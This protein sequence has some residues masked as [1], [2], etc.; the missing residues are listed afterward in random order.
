MKRIT[1]IVLNYKTYDAT[2]KLCKEMHEQKCSRYCINYLIIDN[3][4]NNN[5]YEIIKNSLSEYHD[6]EVIQTKKNEGYARGN[7]V[8]LKYLKRNPPDYVIISNN[9]I[10]FENNTFL[11]AFI[12]KYEQLPE[13]KAIVAPTQLDGSGNKVPLKRSIPTFFDDMFD[14]TVL[15]RKLRNTIQNETKAYS[16]DYSESELIP[17]AFFMISYSTFEKIGFFDESTF[18][19]CE[20]RFLASKVQENHYQNYIID[21]MSYRHVHSYSISTIYS[22]I[23]QKRL[24]NKE[25]INFSHKW[26]RFGRLKGIILALTFFFY[27]YEFMLY[28]FIIHK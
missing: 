18:L 4:S 2:I 26:R 9:D 10:S 17:G 13:N 24:I 12:A 22:F 23:E 11:E 5:S 27:K 1:I 20:E 7:N 25:R 15:L 16:D 28:S 3:S 8:G 6:V 21:S 19:Y 14:N